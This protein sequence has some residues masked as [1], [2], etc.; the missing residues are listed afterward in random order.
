MVVARFYHTLINMFI[1]GFLSFKRGKYCKGTVLMCLFFWGITLMLLGFTGFVEQQLALI[2]GLALAVGAW[3]Y[4]QFGCFRGL[5]R[6]NSEQA[7]DE[8]HHLYRSG[9]EALLVDDLDSAA[10]A[11]KSCR[12]IDPFS[13]SAHFLAGVVE[14][15]RGSKGRGFFESATDMAQ[16]VNWR[17]FIARSRT[18]KRG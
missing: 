18:E 15:Q 1:P 3:L 10:L 7:K 8:L 17:W 2:V 14:Q 4:S 6:A 12:K 11:F 16:S 9:L 5:L 13:V